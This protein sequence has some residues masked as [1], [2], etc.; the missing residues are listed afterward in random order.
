MYGKK[1]KLTSITVCVYISSLIQFTYF[2][3]WFELVSLISKYFNAFKFILLLHMFSQRVTLTQMRVRVTHFTHTRVPLHR[4]R[5]HFK[6]ACFCYCKPGIIIP[7][8]FKPHWLRLISI[9]PVPFPDYKRSLIDSF[10]SF[11]CAEDSV[12]KFTSLIRARD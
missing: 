5:P 8:H 2:L 1:L 3:S 4:T 9:S 12:T 10:I 6:C 11:E 7:W